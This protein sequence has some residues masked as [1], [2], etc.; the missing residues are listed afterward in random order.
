MVR[1]REAEDPVLA[2]WATSCRASA[3]LVGSIPAPLWRATIPGVPTRTVRGIAVHL[4]NAR[5]RWVRTLGAEHGIVAPARLDERTAT[6]R[7]LAAALKRSGAGIA[8][9]LELGIR[10][11]GA[12]PPSRGYAWRNLAL[13]VE[14]V[15]TYFVAHEAHH[16][17]QIV[18][19]ARQLGHRLSGPA[20]AELWRWRPA[21]RAND[22]GTRLSPTRAESGSSSSQARRRTSAAPG[23]ATGRA[24]GRARRRTGARSRG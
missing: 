9:V 19:A 20:M 24:P 8:A 2:A 12:V 5:C 18:M 1:A 3:A 10:N 16:R 11:G 6:P 7:R 21:R 17:G 4:H 15:L 23:A 13:E 22:A 14:H